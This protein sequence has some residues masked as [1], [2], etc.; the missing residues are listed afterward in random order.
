[1][2]CEHCN[3]WVIFCSVNKMNMDDTIYNILQRIEAI[4]I[5]YEVDPP[6]PYEIC[7]FREID[8][9]FLNEILEFSRTHQ[10]D[11]RA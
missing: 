10:I 4:H 1:M 8:E 6:F 7:E 11:N 5:D 9:D 3:D 2:F